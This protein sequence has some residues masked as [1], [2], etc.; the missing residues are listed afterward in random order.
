MTTKPTRTTRLNDLSS[1][2]IP[3]SMIIWRTTSGHRGWWFYSVGG[4]AQWIGANEA[5]AAAWIA[6]R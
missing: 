4:M 5:E 2:K 6:G 3:G 1:A